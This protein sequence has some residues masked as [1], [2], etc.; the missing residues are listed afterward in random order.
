MIVGYLAATRNLKSTPTIGLPPGE[1]KL[2]NGSNN[3]FSSL[4]SDSYPENPPENLDT[5]IAALYPDPG[6]H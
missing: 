3:F 6:S 4:R 5:V 1:Y 2:Y